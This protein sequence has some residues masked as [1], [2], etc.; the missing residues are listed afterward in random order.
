MSAFPS[1]EEFLPPRL[2]LKSM[3]DAVQHCRGCD[4]YKHATQ[5]VFGEGPRSA[6]LILLGEI[7][8]DE[9]DKQGHPFVGPAG[10]LLDHA[11]DDAGLARG[12]VFVT[13]AVKHF[14]WEPRGK[15]RLHKKPSARQIDAC[16]PWLHAE[17]LVVK[18]EGIVCL[19]A[20]A[21]Q[22]ML[23]RQFRITKQRG[24]FFQG[25]D[26]AW[27]MATYHPS[28]ILRAPEKEDR[29]HLRSEF[30]HDLHQAAQ[31]L[32]STAGKRRHVSVHAL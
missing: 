12:E 16:K 11:L 5:A 31:R 25:D 21:A 20:T 3:R 14:R 15:R 7:P 27:L 26:V 18:P 1:A 6:R 8:G 32:N 10:R 4:L 24:K 28:A 2:N 13:N 19:G 23:G 29:D 22:T 30:V 9:E 17:I